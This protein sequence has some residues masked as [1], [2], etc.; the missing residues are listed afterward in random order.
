MEEHGESGICLCS[1]N[2]FFDTEALFIISFSHTI[3]LGSMCLICSHSMS[4]K[5]AALLFFRI[6][7]HF[8]SCSMVNSDA[9]ECSV[10]WFS[11]LL[12]FDGRCVEFPLPFS[13][14]W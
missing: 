12:A 7:I 6:L 2:N 11:V 5:P 3:A 14:S 13:K 1:G 8:I 10:M 9:R 4:S